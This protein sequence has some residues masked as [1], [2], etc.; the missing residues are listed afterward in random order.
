MI[1]G[2]TGHRSFDSDDQKSWI[3][4]QISQYFDI[5]KPEKIISGMAIGS[6][7]IA[8]EV[9]L[10]RNIPYIAAIPFEGQEQKYNLTQKEA[11][12]NYLDKADKTVV[13]CSGTYA[14]W[15]YQKRNKYIVDNSDEMLAIFNKIPKGGTYNCVSY[16]FSNDKVIHY[17]N[18]LEWQK[19]GI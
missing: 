16:A 5:L 1:L 11:Y 18:P 12:Y 14:D 19:S 15:K 9:A 17:I 3:K 13:V 4:L 6:D 7:S 8:I 2:I 10:E